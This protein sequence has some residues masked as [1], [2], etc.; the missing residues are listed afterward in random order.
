MEYLDA[1]RGISLLGILLVNMH[2]HKSSFTAWSLVETYVPGEWNLVT[3]HLIDVFASGKFVAIFAFLFGF[4]LAL[5]ASRWTTDGSRRQSFSGFIFRRMAVLGLL[6]ILH[7]ILLW[8]GDILTLYAAMGLTTVAIHRCRVHTL[9]VLAASSLAVYT[10]SGVSYFHM[11]PPYSEW[12]G[13]WR[14]AADAAFQFPTV[15]DRRYIFF[16][17]RCATGGAAASEKPGRAAT[18]GRAVAARGREW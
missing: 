8:A 10:L 3:V 4:G 6:G 14:G 2:G 17:C 16:R 18:A 7:G 12:E 13:V 1:L 9:L 11:L 5:Q 15:I